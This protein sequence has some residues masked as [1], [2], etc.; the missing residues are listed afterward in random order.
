MEKKMEK[1][2]CRYFDFLRCG[3]DILR[4]NI[5]D[6]FDY[7]YCEECQ[8]KENDEITRLDDGRHT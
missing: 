2:E 8:K 3:N 5:G 4:D 7:P 6:L 1:F